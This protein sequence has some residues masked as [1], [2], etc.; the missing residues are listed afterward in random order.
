MAHWWQMRRREFI[1]LVGGVAATWPLAARAQ[2]PAMPVIGFLHSS[3]PEPNAN[4][5][6]AFRKGLAETG[7]V[8]GQNLAI[9]FRWAEG[10]DDRLPDLAA[11]LIRR[12]VAVIATPASTP[13][14]LAAQAA[15][16]SIPIVFAV[17]ADPVAL[18]LV[19]S[20]NRPGGNA[21][22]VSFQF[23]ELLPKQL[24]MLRELAPGANRFVVLVSRNSAFTDT[25]VKD[26]QASAS[27]IGVPIDIFRVG[28][29]REIDAAFANLVQKP[30]GA[31]LVVPDPFFTNRRAQ[32]VT[33]AA[34]HALPAIYCA[35]EFAEIGGLMSYGPN[36]ADGYRQAGIYV[37]RIL[38]GEKP[39]DLPVVQP[40]KFELVVNLNT[41]R[42]LGITIPN[43][44]LA[45]ADEV[46]E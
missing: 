21:T 26:L 46:I 20:L 42:A 32:I 13:A 25:V 37:G 12:R 14:S 9:E 41:A 33:L 31:L 39:A 29:G 44:L 36:V 11:D 35:P 16:T 7:Y 8:E 28:T 4:R 30:G 18:R 45:L 2:Q 19:A 38:K 23:V 15:T 6:S 3:S 22:G 1:T 34:R 5:V 10:Q 17:A 43:T 27:V 24:G 40:T